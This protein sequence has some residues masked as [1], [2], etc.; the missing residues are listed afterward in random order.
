[1]AGLNFMALPIVVYFIQKVF[2]ILNFLFALEAGD[3]ELDV[4]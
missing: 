1:M 2:S 4:F 3:L